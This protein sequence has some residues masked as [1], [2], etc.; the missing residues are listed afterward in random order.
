MEQRSVII[1]HA[2]HGASAADFRR[3]T[4]DYFRAIEWTIEYSC[5]DS[6]EWRPDKDVISIARMFPLE[7]SFAT[8]PK[9]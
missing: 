2:C 3:V 9:E 7:V 6:E 5:E 1:E 8:L 4:D